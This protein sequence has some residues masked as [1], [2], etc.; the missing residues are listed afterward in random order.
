[1]TQLSL[2]SN[3]AEACK[4]SRDAKMRSSAP[5]PEVARSKTP[6]LSR[7]WRRAFI[8]VVYRN[9]DGVRD[10]RG[11]IDSQ[12]H[13]DEGRWRRALERTAGGADLSPQRSRSVGKDGS[14]RPCWSGKPTPKPDV[15]S[16]Y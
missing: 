3:Q 6:A 5:E 4:F 12:W 14:E 15:S 7:A 10:Y 1:M 2:A 8:V 9:A 11:A 16:D 13:Y